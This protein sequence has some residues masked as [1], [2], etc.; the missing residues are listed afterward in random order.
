MARKF[1]STKNVYYYLEMQNCIE[2]YQGVRREFHLITG[3]PEKVEQDVDHS[4]WTITLP[5]GIGKTKWL[6]AQKNFKK[7]S[8][9][10]L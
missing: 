10:S 8:K 1:I 7:N 5:A 3:I 4:N 6:T 9:K 2:M